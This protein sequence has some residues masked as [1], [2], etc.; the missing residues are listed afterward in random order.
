MNTEHTNEFN[1]YCC[2]HAFKAICSFKV[3]HLNVK[4][5]LMH[6]AEQRAMLFEYGFGIVRSYE[7]I[8]IDSM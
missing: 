7:P 5:K 1:G 3:K 8:L 4:T 2:F 6:I